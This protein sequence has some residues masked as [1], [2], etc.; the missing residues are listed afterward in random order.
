MPEYPAETCAMCDNDL[1]PD[2]AMECSDCSD[3]P[4][5]DGCYWE[6]VSRC[7]YE[8]MGATQ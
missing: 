4:Y 2:D 7:E 3:G 5:C 6:H 1:D 8:G